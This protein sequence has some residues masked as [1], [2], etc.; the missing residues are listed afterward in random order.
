M[1]VETSIETISKG[2]AVMQ[3]KLSHLVHN[4]N[5]AW[6]GKYF[7]QTGA[8]I[9]HSGTILDQQQ[10]NFCVRFEQNVVE[11]VQISGI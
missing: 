5:I 8:I 1:I 4:I 9:P 3:V 7:N 6:V 2:V 11:R 10:Q